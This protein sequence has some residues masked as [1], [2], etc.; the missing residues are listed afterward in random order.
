MFEASPRNNMRSV[1]KN[2]LLGEMWLSKGKNFRCGEGL[3][4]YVFGVYWKMSSPDV[5]IML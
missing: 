5:K 3:E 4:F 2:F 1:T